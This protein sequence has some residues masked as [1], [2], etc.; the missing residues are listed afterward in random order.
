MSDDI[1]SLLKRLEAELHWIDEHACSV[2]HGIDSCRVDRG[3]ELEAKR[4]LESVASTRACLDALKAKLFGL[5]DKATDEAAWLVYTTTEEGH[6]GVYLWWKPNRSGYTRYV[7]EAGRY[8]K[9]E[10]ES[11]CKMRGQEGAVSVD[12]VAA[13][14]S[15]VLRIGK[16]HEKLTPGV[17]GG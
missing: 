15:S 11:I 2:K 13:Q 16:L 1:K 10:A 3:T 9:S 4:L 12:V 6:G 7:E 8:T 17:H 5:P 14:T